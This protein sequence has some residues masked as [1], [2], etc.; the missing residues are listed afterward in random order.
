L[1]S[2]GI[3][4]WRINATDVVGKPDFVF[5]NAQ[6]AVFVDGCFWHGCRRCR[7]I[8]ATN[9]EFWTK[10]I[11]ANKKRDL[12]VT[13]ILEKSGWRV[14][15]FWEHELKRQPEKCVTIIR[16]AI[17]ETNKRQKSKNK[18]GTQCKPA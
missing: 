2:A 9:R 11:Q 4:G 12:K 5:D 7:N 14:F 18:L 6:I 17:E 16:S 8:P 10:K 13:R 1:I 15:R 3:S